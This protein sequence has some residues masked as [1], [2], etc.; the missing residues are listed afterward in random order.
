MIIF[1]IDSSTLGEIFN[2]ARDCPD[3]VDQIPEAQDGFYWIVLPN[4]KKHKVCDQHARFY[5]ALLFCL[6]IFVAYYLKDLNSFTSF[7]F[8]FFII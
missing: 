5:I 2:P 8:T 7:I 3:I 6:K 1:E 4:G